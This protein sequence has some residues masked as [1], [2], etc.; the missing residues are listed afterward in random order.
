MYTS[1]DGDRIEESTIA[2]RNV[3]ALDA[4]EPEDYK[5]LYEAEKQKVENFEAQF[6]EADFKIANKVLEDEVKIPGIESLRKILEQKNQDI[7]EIS[8]QKDVVEQEFEYYKNDV[9]HTVEFE[10]AQRQTEIAYEDKINHWKSEYEKANEK[11]KDINC[12]PKII[13]FSPGR[14]KCLDLIFENK[15]GILYLQHDGH[16]VTKVAAVRPVEQ[17]GEIVS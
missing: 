5:S 11:L 2:D 8:K 6:K 4:E 14:L 15:D 7:F 17:G 13:E 1:T 12:L 10:K 16:K 3:V 9:R